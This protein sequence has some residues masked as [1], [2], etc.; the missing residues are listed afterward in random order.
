MYL[1]HVHPDACNRRRV[2]ACTAERY[3]MHL[4]LKH[5][6]GWEVALVRLKTGWAVGRFA[7]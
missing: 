1:L 4:P 2:V 3:Y 5:D 6:K 7:A